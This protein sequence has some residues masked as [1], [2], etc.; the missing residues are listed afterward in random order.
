TIIAAPRHD[1]NNTAATEGRPTSV[2]NRWRSSILDLLSSALLGLLVLL[3]AAA[4]YDLDRRPAEAVALAD[5]VLEVAL[6]APVDLLGVVGEE[7]EHRRRNLR[8]CGVVDPQVRAFVDRGRRM[9]VDRLAQQRV[10]LGG[11]DAALAL[12]GDLQRQGQHLLDPLAA[13]G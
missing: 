4:E 5:A 10:Q 9:V 3:L 1:G 8:L 7:Q 2:M 12:L 6:I 13:L 11:G